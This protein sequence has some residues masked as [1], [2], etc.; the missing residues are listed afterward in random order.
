MTE[1]ILAK[2]A[3]MRTISKLESVLESFLTDVWAS[4]AINPDKRPMTPATEALADE[5]WKRQN[6]PTRPRNPANLRLVVNVSL[7]HMTANRE[8]NKGD[9]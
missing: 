5:G 9:V 6:T 2:K 1:K 4:P 7:S 8:T 3:Y